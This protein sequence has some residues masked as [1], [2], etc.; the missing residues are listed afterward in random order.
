MSILF[1]VIQ[2]PHGQGDAVQAFPNN[3][4]IFKDVGGIIIIVTDLLFYMKR[5]GK[6]VTTDTIYEKP[7]VEKIEFT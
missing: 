4:L 5:A 2:G 7:S 1:F 3:P 6:C